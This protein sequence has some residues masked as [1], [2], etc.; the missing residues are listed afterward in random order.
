M[1]IIMQTISIIE[2][3]HAFINGHKARLSAE[4]SDL[5]RLLNTYRPMLYQQTPYSYRHTGLLAAAETVQQISYV[6]PRSAVGTG[7]SGV[8]EISRLWVADIK[9]SESHEQDT[10]NAHVP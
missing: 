5:N 1:I 10:R 7:V 8:H 2:L 9:L 4:W 3:S 6:W